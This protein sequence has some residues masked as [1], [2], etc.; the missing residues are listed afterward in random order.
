MGG[1]QMSEAHALN[2]VILSLYH[3]GR[4]VPL[5]SFQAWALEQLQCLIVFDSAWWGNAAANPPALHQMHLYQCDESIL[6]AYP[7]YLE[8]DLFRAALIAR[9]GTT[10]NLSDLT[11]RERHVRTPLYREF[12]RR[13]KVEWSLGTLVIEP[14]SS[15]YEFLTLWRHDPGRPFSEAERQTKELLMPHLVETHRAV[16]LRHFL[17]VPADHDREWA[18]VDARAFLREASPAFIAR[19]RAQW[20]GWSGSSLPEPLASHAT[21]GSPYVSAA[22]HFDVTPCGQLRYLVARSE[23]ALAQLS[24]R[25][26]EIATRYAGGETYSAI[27]ASLSLSPTTVR[28]HIAHCFHKLGVN[29]KAELARRLERKA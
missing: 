3:E 17:K 5:G 6:E 13:F 1:M 18:V 10:V 29:N 22:V 28:N 24:G 11:T 20:P 2:R 25:E 26:R 19:L 21:R 7:P 9:P 15:L 16:R 27:A 4:E 12:A 23:G 8:Q 14:V